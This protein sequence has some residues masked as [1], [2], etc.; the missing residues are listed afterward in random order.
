[1]LAEAGTSPDSL[2][3]RL[4]QD[5]EGARLELPPGQWTSLSAELLSRMHQ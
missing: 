4:D 2:A 5:A 3:E 1:V